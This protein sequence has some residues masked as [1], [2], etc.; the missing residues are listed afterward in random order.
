[1]LALGPL[2]FGVPWILLGLLAIPAIL[3]LLRLTPPAPRAVPFP[4][5]RLLFGLPATREEPQ[6]SPLWLLL[7]RA[8]LAALLI[9]ALAGPVYRA[10][11]QN[12]PARPLLLAV[13]DGWASADGWAARKRT[14][15]ALIDEA[16]RQ[17]V[18]V[19]LL[20]TAPRGQGAEL[21]L[22]RMTAGDA[23]ARIDA[24]D[25]VPW[26]VDR[27]AAARRLADAPWTDES[28]VVWLT[29][30]LS[31]PGTDA[32][33]SALKH[34]GPLTIAS[35]PPAAA[36]VI[37]FPAQ[38]ADGSAFTLRRARS[39][40]AASGR[41]AAR[42]TDGRLLAEAPFSFAT[43][44]AQTTAV[45]TLPGTARE[46]VASL[47]IE[48]HRSA[49]AIFLVDE[50]GRRRSVGLVSGGVSE[51]GQPLLSDLFYLDRA[52]SPFA[53]VTRGTIETLAT[54]ERAVIML[55]D[56]GRMPALQHDKLAA[57]IEAGGTL[58]RFA[59]PHLAAPHSAGESD[60]LVP[61]PLREG[62]R[63]LGG[64][65]SWDAPEALGPFDAD[66]PFA[67]LPTPTDIQVRRQVL[68]EPVPDLGQKTWAR[69]AD[70]TPLV[71]AA[72]R[73]AGRI[74][75]VHVTAN[76]D[77][78]DLPLSGT[79]VS[80]LRRLVQLAH[81]PGRGT[82]SAA[83]GP[84]TLT[85][86]RMLDAYGDL[87]SPPPTAEPLDQAAI[88]ASLP[89]PR[90][91]PGLYGPGEEARAFN[92][93]RS[94]LSLVPFVPPKAVSDTALIETHTRDLA[95]AFLAM[96]FALALADGIAVLLL[97]GG[98]ALLRQRLARF[99]GLT[100]ALVLLL[101]VAGISDAKAQSTRTD[102]SAAIA[103]LHSLRLAYV[104]TGDAQVDALSKA[105]LEGLTRTL[106]ERT[107]VE[108]DMPAGVDLEADELAYFPLLYWQ[109]APS[110]SPLSDAA[111]SRLDRFMKTG[112]TLIIDTADADRDFGGNTLR[113][114][115]ARLRVILA[116]LDL[117]PLE[118]LPGDH[119]L[120]KSFYLLREF[121]GRY[122]NGRLW[123][124]AAR[125][126]AD[127]DGV[128]SII[129]GANDWAGAWAR[130]ANGQPL[131][132]L[133]PGGERQRELATR[134][135]VNLVMYALTGNYK[136]DQVHVPALLERLGQ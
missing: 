54:P 122:V 11:A 128:A 133:T 126:G 74:V 6:R 34:R 31:A 98:Y 135:G 24:L 47:S 108:P 113:P 56:V 50:A 43:G 8:L 94:S 1:M 132:P 88:T 77:W 26:P 86:W 25:P 51:E 78:S 36:P 4:A 110:E 62:G 35:P 76:T 48:G 85:P 22:A 42:G 3:W 32:L 123:V 115:E 90:H 41:I 124:E 27:D 57:W 13:D 28:R 68:A 93:A 129:V 107:A 33:E 64:A 116:H 89:G 117:P 119:V 49:G 7:L 39:T 67:G 15:I 130:D 100:A 38:S 106:S 127:H 44:A 82:G 5:I 136:A 69:L 23:H 112:G 16:G 19:A 97:G 95:P 105:G 53:S 83:A 72:P 111:V 114:G 121:P 79:Y 12:G 81:A 92:L 45:L 21:P 60:D 104:R 30:G 59:G 91:P 125:G 10:T 14:M 20:F 61:V 55:A 46:D 70:G 40:E 63:T 103:A 37:L 71:T 73:G 96:A 58:V 17:N 118:P 65:L 101:A 131:V 87:L 29:D 9:L 66:G 80:M 99:A 18:P 109:I 84:Q 134:F 52:L 2:S 102:D 120:T 75:L